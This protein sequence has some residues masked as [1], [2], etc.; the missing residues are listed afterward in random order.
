MKN[1][2][3]MFILAL[4]L[5]M[6]GIGVVF[7][8]ERDPEG[9]NTFTVSPDPQ[10]AGG[11]VSLDINMTV[12]TDHSD[13]C[14]YTPDTPASSD[15]ITP[16]TVITLTYQSSWPPS[17]TVFSYTRV[18]SFTCPAMDDRTGFA[19]SHAG[20]IGSNNVTLEGT[21]DVTISANAQAGE[22]NWTLLIEAAAAGSPDTLSYNHEIQLAAT[23]IYASDSTTCQGYGTPG[24]SCFQSLQSAINAVTAGNDVVIVGDL[25][26]SDGGATT[27]A[28][29]GVIRG[30]DASAK[31]NAS[32]GCAGAP[33]TIDD[34]NTTVRDFVVDGTSCSAQVGIV[35][36][37][38][39]VALNNMTVQDFGSTAGISFT[40]NCSGSLKNST[41]QNNNLGVNVVA[42]AAVTV[43]IGTGPSDG[44][45]FSN[46]ATG[47]QVNDADTSIKGNTISGGSI[48]I[49]VN[50]D[51]ATIY[52]NSVTGASGNQIDCSNDN[53]NAAG[54]NY[55]GGSSPTSGS[56]CNDKEDQI[57]E[58]FGSN[59]ADGSAYG[60]VSVS[61]GTGIAVFQLSGDPYTFGS[62]DGDL[63]AFY[64]VK[65]SGSLTVTHSGSGT[66]A[67]MMM[68]ATGCSPMTITCWESASDENPRPQTG[69]G[70]YAVGNTDPTVITLRSVSV[71]A[72]SNFM[73]VLV[74][75]LALV[76][77]LGAV[78][79][80]RRK[81]S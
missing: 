43:E 47:I 81:R 22:Y 42:G 7:A 63:T 15:T 56:N 29:S 41:I 24:T 80:V 76:V 44:N 68:D 39:G 79:V 77:S 53:W 57:G 61:G 2:R 75:G 51:G 52:G 40:T 59:W 58:S 18:T 67:K 11:A 13:F 25:A 54:F 14:L 12:M 37:A 28:N 3:F 74:I 65:G 55:L 17:S 48:G 78:V 38:T 10:V 20:N 62:G 30:I 46:N 26:A 72:N 69:K 33:L 36:S 31:L 19:Y 73:P 66:Q 35:V 1:F 34:N 32:S 23:T 27:T 16:T 50:T 4:L 71:A 6:V 9:I 64:A 45:T 60:D 5:T 8:Q 49:D 21:T 70:Y